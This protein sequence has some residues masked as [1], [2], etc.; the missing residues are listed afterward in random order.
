[1]ALWICLSAMHVLCTRPASSSQSVAR[2]T[3]AKA[4]TMMV[5]AM[6]AG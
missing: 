3:L 4:L 1:V 6:P 5:K 2:A